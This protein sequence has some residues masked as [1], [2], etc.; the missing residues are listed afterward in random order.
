MKT[1]LTSLFLLIGL[2]VNAQS[3][4]TNTFQA[5]RLWND[6]KEYPVYTAF[7]IF[8]IQT[9]PKC[10]D[11]DTVKLKMEYEENVKLIKAKYPNAK[12]RQVVVRYQPS[13]H[14]VE[15]TFGKFREII[16]K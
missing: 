8:S 13:N 11:F 1:I 4:Q 16:C 6:G 2:V 9:F 5:R 15:L 3:N 10:A 7:S 14:E 12:F